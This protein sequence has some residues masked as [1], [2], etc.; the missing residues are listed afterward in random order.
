MLQRTVADLRE[1]RL[2]T[3]LIPKDYGLLSLVAVIYI[4]D[5]IKTILLKLLS[6]GCVIIDQHSKLYIFWQSCA[7]ILPW[8]HLLFKIFILAIEAQALHIFFKYNNLCRSILFASFEILF[9]LFIYSLL[10]N[11]S[12]I[13]DLDQCKK[14]M[15]MQNYFNDQQT[16]VN[17]NK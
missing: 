4:A 13:C 5:C 7:L 6:L 12:R 15:Y 9:S 14:V 1:A 2:G 16:S 8:W 11:L 3:S 17:K 10:R